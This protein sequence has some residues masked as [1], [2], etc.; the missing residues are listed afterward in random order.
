MLFIDSNKWLQLKTFFGH[1]MIYTQ[2]CY[3]LFFTDIV[4]TWYIIAV[5]AWLIRVLSFTFLPSLFTLK[6]AFLNSWMGIKT[7]EY[8]MT[9]PRLLNPS[10]AAHKSL[11][12]G[13]LRF[14]YKTSYHQSEIPMNTPVLNCL[15]PSYLYFYFVHLYE[16]LCSLVWC[17]GSNIDSR[18]QC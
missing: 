4:T 2:C 18:D 15:V 8:V 17:N 1:Q 16:I 7:W 9:M 12:W 11:S 5:Y 13:T 3:F 14:I 6:Y 10:N